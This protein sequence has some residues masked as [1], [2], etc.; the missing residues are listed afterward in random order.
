MNRR[1]AGL[2]VAAL[3]VVFCVGVAAAAVGI[4]PVSQNDEGVVLRQPGGA[5]VTLTGNTD[6][7][8]TSGA[9]DSTTIQWNVTEGSARFSASNLAQATIDKDDL[10][11]TWTNLT[12]MDVTGGA[13]TINPADKRSITV[14]G[15]ADTL[16][17]RDAKLDDGNPDFVIEGTSGSSSVTLRGLPTSTTISAVNQS[18]GNPLDET[19]SDA[20]GVATFDISHSTQTVVLQSGTVAGTP[21]QSEAAPTGALTS[22]PS[23]LSIQIND[24][25]FPSDQ[26][27][28][29]FHLD[30]SQIDSQ[31]ITSNGTVTAT[32]P[33]S[34]KTGGTHNWAVN[35]SDDFGNVNNQS[36]SYGVPDELRIYNETQSETLIQSPTEVTVQFFAENGS[37][38]ER[39]TT[40]GVIDFSGLP[41]DQAFVVDAQAADFHDRRIYIESLIQQQEIYLLNST[42]FSGDD[43]VFLIEDNSGQF[44]PPDDT[45]LFVEKALNISGDVQY[46]VIT[47]DLFSATNEVPVTLESDQRYRLRLKGPDNNTRVLGAYRSTG[48]DNAVLEVGTVTFEGANATNPDF[49]ATVRE[50]DG[51]RVI[52]IAYRDPANA[53]TDLTLEVINRTNSSDVLRP[54]TTETG[55]FGTYVE[56]I[57]I[58][59]SKENVAYNVSWSATRE[60]FDDQSSVAFVGDLPQL[61]DG[62]GLDDTVLWLLGQL[63]IFGVL[64]LTCIS[65]PR[66]AGI[67]TVAIAA[68]LTALG[69]VAIHPLL[70]GGAGV[71]AI[72][73][74]VGGA[75]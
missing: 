20:N 56:T 41:A 69:I 5:N 52:R 36:Y 59:S 61:G 21:R 8:N 50:I 11:G 72:T 46:R 4:I 35:S 51:N 3:F 7:R 65:Y 66:Y 40:N 32:I 16:D 13:L 68:G 70:V 63:T 73:F 17:F 45:V 42:V 48:D 12:A 47:S 23:Q 62:F 38:Y 25:D 1:T 58:S 29:D 14:Q 6:L 24:S 53:T 54:Q 15:N 18:T 34:G 10:E 27:T 19:S 67:P 75:R 44:T 60:S 64:A 28:V 31:T 74:A 2:I 22:D 57:P 39:S 9:V 30:G 49:R 37:V 33:S 43:V 71:I 26:M 55:P